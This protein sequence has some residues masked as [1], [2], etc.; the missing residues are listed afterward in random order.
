MEKYLVYNGLIR[1]KQQI[2]IV[3]KLKEEMFP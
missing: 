3:E 2:I 1:E